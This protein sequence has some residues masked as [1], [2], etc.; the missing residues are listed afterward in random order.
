MSKSRDT[1]ESIRTALLDADIGTSVLAPDGDGSNLTGINAVVVGSTLPSDGAAAASLFYQTSNNKLY[2]SDGSLWALVANQGPTPTGGTVVIPSV[3][4]LSGSYSY[5]LGQ[6]FTDDAS[7][8]AELT[9][10]LNSGALP[11]GAVLP[12]TGN[13]AFTGTIP[14]VSS[15]TLFSFQITATDPSGA[16]NKQNYQQ[17]ITNSLPA[18]TGGTV[19]LTSVVESNAASYDVDTDFTFSSGSVFSAYS[20][21]SGTLPTGT[22]LNTSTGVISGT[23]S[24]SGSYSFSIR[25]TAVDGGTSEQSYTWPIS[26]V[27]PT[28][29][30]GTITIS[31]ADGLDAVSYDADT[32]F[33]FSAGSTFSAYSIGSGAIPSGTSLN[34]STGVISGTLSNSSTTYTFAIRATDTDGDTVDQNYSWTITAFVPLTATGGTVTTYGIYKLHTFTSSST[35]SVSAGGVADVLVVGGGG[36]GGIGGI[37]GGGG[38]GGMHY[39]TGLAI[40][41]ANYTITVGAGGSGTYANVAQAGANGSA[42][43]A[44][45]VTADGGGGGGNGPSGSN[46]ANGGGGGGY[47]S[48]TTQGYGQGAGVGGAGWTSHGGY[49]GGAGI[50]HDGGGGG[51]A[52][53]NGNPANNAS[54]GPHGGIGVSNSITGSALYWAGGGGGTYYSSSA[55][56]A[57]GNGGNGGGGGGVN[58]GRPSASTGGLGY[59]YGGAGAT[60]YSG[61]GG[62]AGANTGGGGGGGNESNGDGGNGGS[63]IVIVRYVA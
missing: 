21:F 45:G 50:T 34:T 8:D 62:D 10:T 5:N 60:V 3:V 43:S 22:S 28:S 11:T 52:G 57:A 40:S 15:D 37:S 13:T 51:G 42:S 54:A 46:G 26:T 61:D 58:S 49:D 6:D 25:A 16:T 29:T 41:A 2:I 59:N 23:A 18:T 4:E 63:G 31:G 19:T 30:G 39:A 7:T 17:T 55:T 53:A 47:S 32:D 20:L 38:A 35:L 1:V 24:H 48:G 14:T 33:T 9:Y 36:A 27:A 12:T 44:F 56:N